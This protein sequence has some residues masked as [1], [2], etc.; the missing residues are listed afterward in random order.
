MTIKHQDNTSS[1][2]S[3]GASSRNGILI[4]KSVCV[5]VLEETVSFGR[6]INVAEGSRLNIYILL[7]T[8]GSIKPKGFHEA[9]D[10]TIALINKVFYLLASTWTL[11]ALTR[12]L[13][14]WGNYGQTTT[15]EGHCW[16]AVFCWGGVCSVS[17]DG[18]R[19]GVMWCHSVCGLSLAQLDSYE[20][21]I[22]YHILSFAS[23]PIDIVDIRD[24]AISGSTVNVL[25]YLREFDSK[26]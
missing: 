6:S 17:P 2:G 19:D 16:I 5:C 15:T 24:T 23:E 11:Q 21:Q 7:D 26:S 20:V 4:L 12:S 25:H 8:S 22:L 14:I 18:W 10:A 3:I 13:L 9:R 1:A